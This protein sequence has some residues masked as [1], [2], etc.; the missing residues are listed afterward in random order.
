[1]GAYRSWLGLALLFLCAAVGSHV[2]ADLI[3]Q[4]RCFQQ[5][6]VLLVQNQTA[7][8]SGAQASSSV[9]VQDAAAVSHAHV[10]PWAKTLADNNQQMKT[11]D[12]PAQKLSLGDF[13]VLHQIANAGGK[14]RA[15]IHSYAACRS[16]SA[17]LSQP[18]S[19]LQE[20]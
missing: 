3:S 12:T 17:E 6:A 14:I 11:A 4:S 9:R 10:C 13:N 15:R 1:M 8:K 16:G 2:V 18:V 20:E 7:T 5:P 19:K